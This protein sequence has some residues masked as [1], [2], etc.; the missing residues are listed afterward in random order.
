MTANN[1]PISFEPLLTPEDLKAP[2][3][4]GS[5]PGPLARFE[6]R[7]KDRARRFWGNPKNRSNF[8]RCAAIGLPV[9]LLAGAGLYWKFGIV[10]QPNFLVDDLDSVLNFALLTDEFNKLPIQERLALVGQLVERMRSMNAEDSVMFAAFAAGLQGKMREQLIG[11]ASSLAVDLFDQ[12]AAKYDAVTDEDREKYIEDVI[13]DMVRTAETISGQT[14]RQS[15]R[16]LLDMMKR[17]SQRQSEAVRTGRAPGPS[18]EIAARIFS[19]LQ[20][21]VGRSANAQ[22]RARG[23]RLMRDMT[24][25]FRG[26]DVSTGQP[27]DGPG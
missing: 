1:P 4:R 19:T 26:Q 25:Y 11:N 22:Q 13:I 2:P 16:E 6:Q 27:K 10:H 18:G 17:Q 9:L 14:R 7:L 20:N 23:T 24:R 15:D 21:D 8:R 3:P 5:G 12:Y